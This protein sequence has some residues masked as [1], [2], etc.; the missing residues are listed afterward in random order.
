VRHAV[1]ILVPGP[2]FAVPAGAPRGTYAVVPVSAGFPPVAGEPFEAPVG[3]EAPVPE[4]QG[5]EIAGDFAILRG[6]NF[7]ETTWLEVFSPDGP[8]HRVRP[9]MREDGT[10]ELDVRGVALP[11]VPIWLRPHN[12]PPGGGPGPRFLLDLARP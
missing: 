8:V 10:L 1:Q 9:R 6:R 5:V 11:R 12:L 3:E 2:V 7:T 4:L